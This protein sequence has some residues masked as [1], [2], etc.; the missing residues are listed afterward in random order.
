MVLIKRQHTIS[1]GE[2]I[3]VVRR[4]LMGPESAEHRCLM[5][6]TMIFSY[7]VANLND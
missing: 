3:K 5:P 7:T 2:R 4:F 1:L 6:H